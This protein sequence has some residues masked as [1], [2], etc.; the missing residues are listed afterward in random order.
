M[1]DVV[2]EF[3]QGDDFSIPFTMTD[4]NNSNASIDITSWVI[5]SQIRYSKKLIN[6]VTVAV[7][8]AVNGEFTLSVPK[9]Q[10]LL[11]LP[12]RKLLCN[13]QFDQLVGGR[14]SSEVFSI[15]VL[16]DPTI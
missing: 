2:Y 12:E 5:T 3:F 13:V 8:S 11:W 1:A 9:E 15:L 14:V 4:P 10:T 7:T 16:E 6:D